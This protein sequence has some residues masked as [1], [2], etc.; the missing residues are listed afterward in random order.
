MADLK[1]FFSGKEGVKRSQAFIKFAKL[2]TEGK[3]DD[4]DDEKEEPKKDKKVQTQDDKNTKG[5]IELSENTNK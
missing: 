2:L 1:K 5:E 3:G 4:K